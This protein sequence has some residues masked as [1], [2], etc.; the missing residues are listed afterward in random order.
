MRSMGSLDPK[1]AVLAELTDANHFP[2][3]VISSENGVETERMEATRCE[4]KKMD[5][6]R[7]VVPPGYQ[8]IDLAAMLQ[9][10]GGLGGPPGSGRPPFP[11]PPG[12]PHGKPK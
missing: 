3:R 1:A 2:L 7:F 6:A 11:V 5:D 10:F 12:P 4:K 8:I 9:G